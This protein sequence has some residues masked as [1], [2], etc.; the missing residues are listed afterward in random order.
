MVNGCG[1]RRHA[2][3][4]FNKNSFAKQSKQKS[5]TIHHSPFILTMEC[6]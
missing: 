5:F 3:P 2:T 4:F 6:N 1:K